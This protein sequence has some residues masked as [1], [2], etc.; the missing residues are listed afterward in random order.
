VDEEPAKYSQDDN[1]YNEN[2]KEFQ[3]NDAAR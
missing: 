1:M 2:T 3:N